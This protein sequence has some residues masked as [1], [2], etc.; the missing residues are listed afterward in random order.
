MRSTDSYYRPT[1]QPDHGPAAIDAGR[2]VRYVEADQ[3]KPRAKNDVALVAGDDTI[4]ARKARSCLTALQGGCRRSFSAL[5]LLVSLPLL[6]AIALA[7]LVT[8]GRPIFHRGT[9]LGLHKR[10]FKMYKFRTLLSGAEKMTRGRLLTRHDGI[11]TPIGWFLRDTRL[12]ELPQL[13][14]IVK[15]EMRFVGPRPVRPDVYE[16]LCK[17]IA[18][19][20]VRFQGKPGLVGHSQIFTPHNTPKRMRS[21]IDRRIGTRQAHVLGRILLVAYTARVFARTVA[22]RVMRH[23]YHDVLLR[24]ILQRYREKRTLARVRPR[25]A[26]A[27][28][29]WNGNGPGLCRA[30]VLD[31]NDRAF[32]MHCTEP[33]SGPFPQRFE[34]EIKTGRNGRI[35]KR[36]ATCT[37]SVAQVRPMPRGLGY[38]VMF[39]PATEKSLFVVHQHFLRRSLAHPSG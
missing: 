22:A 12:D 23:V 5:L 39:E 3:S 18:R 20:D 4:G 13:L 2:V 38:V 14:N 25:R 9:R 33:I 8:S 28:V 27:A 32:L 30:P 17:G 7:V 15:G 1:A 24:R 16:S 29:S 34:L 35:Q 6:L 19:Y 10:P 37:G 21:L 11:T 26:A 36:K 31:I